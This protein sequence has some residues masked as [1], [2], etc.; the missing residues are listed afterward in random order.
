MS[1]K[2]EL[3]EQEQLFLDYLFDG[4][5]I[6]HPNE[7]K[8]LAGYAKDYPLSK[9]LKNI[10]K[11]LVER[12]D[13][14]LTL[15]APKGVVGLLNIINDPNEPGTKIRLQAITDLLDR[16]GVVKKEKSEVMQAQPNFMFVLPSKTSIDNIEIKE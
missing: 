15:Y 12:C 7:A 14:Y 9:I 4:D 11:E 13:N 6:R 1:D 8:Q 2:K 5:V 10:N 3:T 16:A